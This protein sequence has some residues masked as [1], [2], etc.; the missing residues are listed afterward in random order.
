MRKQFSRIALAAGF[1]LA[2]AFTLSCGDHTTEDDNPVSSSSLSSSGGGVVTPSS[3]GGVVTPSSSSGKSSSSNQTGSV[4]EK[5]TFIDTRDNQ[6][7]DW[8][9]IGTQTWMAEN[10]NYKE[11]PVNPDPASKRSSR[12]YNNIEVNCSIYGRLYEWDDALLVCPED[13]HLPS[14]A[15]WDALISFVGTDAG[16]KLKATNS[17]GLWRDETGGTDEYSFGGRPGGILIS[18][19]ER[20]NIGGY[21]WTNSEGGTVWA[22]EKHMSSGNN[23]EEDGTGLRNKTSFMS[24]RCVKGY[25]SSS[26]IVYGNV[27]DSRDDQTYPTVKIGTQTWMAKNLNFAGKGVCYNGQSSNCDKYGRLYDWATAMNVSEGY[28]TE[29]LNA[30]PGYRQGICMEGWH[31]PTIAEW[32]DMI[33]YVEQDASLNY[34][35]GY[36]AKK[37]KAKRVEWGDYYGMDSYG[38]EGLPGGILISEFER[39]NMGGYWWTA[40]EGGEVWAREKH[41]SSSNNVEEALDYLRNKTSFMSVRCVKN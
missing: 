7:Y 5:G 11:D 1:G 38:F 20:L 25:S 30:T 4:V 36:A 2:L 29:L 28:N 22:Y 12:C 18:E 37:L 14:K 27:T 8:V 39:L 23:V 10:L 31:L 32:N 19:F 15:E 24:V 17:E 34:K 33:S 13:W 16:K 21:W 6:K 3:S 41:M 40:S 26:S 9:K 35:G